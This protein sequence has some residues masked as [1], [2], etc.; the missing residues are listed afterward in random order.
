FNVYLR[1]DWYLENSFT[2][3]IILILLATYKKFQFS[4]TSYILFFLFLFL[5]TVGVHYTYG[6][7]PFGYIIENFLNLP[8]QC[9]N[10]VVFLFSHCQFLGSNN[11]DRII[12]FLFG[13]ILIY[14]TLEYF[15]KR[16]K[17]QGIW[18]TILGISFLAFLSLSYETI[19]MIVIKVANPALGDSFL[20][21]QGDLW[22]S[23]KDITCQLV[24]SII[25]SLFLFIKSKF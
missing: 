16:L 18:L 22:D 13:A 5:H 8:S 23:Q 20:A 9:N 19:E 24:G 1:S 2:L 12:H 7:V 25:S 11:F 21:T 4:L 3:A 6:S 15:R 14:P 10:L 17:L